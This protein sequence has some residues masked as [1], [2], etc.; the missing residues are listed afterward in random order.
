MK[1]NYNC[2]THL[3]E[4]AKELNVID[5]IAFIENGKTI[6]YGQLYSNAKEFGQSLLK[7]GQKKSDRVILSK[8]DSIEFVVNFL[9]FLYVGVIPVL[10]NS[11]MSQNDIDDITKKIQ[12]DYET[13]GAFILC[14]SGTT[15]QTKLVIHS[16]ESICGT[17]L[18]YGKILQI[19]KDDVVFSAAKMTHAYGLGNSLSI[20]LTYGATVILE[21]ELPT[22]EKIVSH[23]ENGKVSIFCGVPRHFT[24]LL[25]TT[26][27]Y[28]FG[29][30]RICLSAGESLP[31]KVGEDFTN[32]YGC[33]ILDA[34]GSTELLGFALTTRIDEV[35]YGVTGKP[36]EGVDVKLVDEYGVEVSTGEIGE[37]FVRSEFASTNYYDDAPATNYTFRDG[38]IKTND[39]YQ[40]KNDQFIHRGR[41]NDCIKINGLYV[42]LTGL[43][44]DLYEVNSILEAAVVS[45]DNKYG[46]SRIE[47]FVVLKDGY[48]KK[49]EYVNILERFKT[50]NT[51]F[52]RPYTI[53]MVDSLPRT[54]SGKI[55][56]YILLSRD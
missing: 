44:K 13:D 49:Q 27:N 36:V 34:I 28:D 48:D 21:P 4:I 32:R 37:L 55:K 9:G 23:I 45:G 46:L 8:K 10:V 15:G 41:R 47:I 26:R 54:A 30:L 50:H 33:D 20:P 5:K 2:L 6:T 1:K 12:V 16:H 7:L 3:E 52:K 19:T 40:V 35:V 39:M 29:S 43:E 25:N 38:W 22:P 31:K 42:S 53:K 18:Q 17:G 24:S 51:M 11:S 14:T 56:K